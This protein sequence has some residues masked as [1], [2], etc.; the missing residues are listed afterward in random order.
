[1]FDELNYIQ[2]H[3]SHVLHITFYDLLMFF[4]SIVWT[5]FWKLHPTTNIISAYIVVVI[6]PI[7]SEE[8]FE[9]ISLNC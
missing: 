8:R 6:Q 9:N 7:N 1:M 4:Y 3:H 5:R 2:L